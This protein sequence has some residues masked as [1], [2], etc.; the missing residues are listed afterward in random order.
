MYAMLRARTRG[1]RNRFLA[2]VSDLL[3]IPSYSLQEEQLAERVEAEMR[4]LRFEEVFRDETGNVIGIN[5]GRDADK[6]LLLN[7]HMDTVEVGAEEQW[8]YPP[9]LAQPVYP[10][11]GS[12]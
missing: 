1:L 12:R 4:S 7:S 11:C 2:F 6:T 9:E 10:G 5:F 8:R 3:R